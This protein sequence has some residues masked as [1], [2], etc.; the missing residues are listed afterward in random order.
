[1]T[2]DNLANRILA[3]IRPWQTSWYW[4]D[5]PVAE[6]GAAREVLTAAGL[7]IDD[8]CSRTDDPPDCEANIDGQRCGIELTTLEHEGMIRRAL[9]AIR[10]RASGKE[11]KRPEAYFVWDRETFLAKLQRIIHRKD[12]QAARAQGG[13]YARYILIIVTAEM[14]LDRD[15][16][17]RFLP[18]ACFRAEHI[19]DVFLGLDYHPDPAGG[20]GSYPTFRLELR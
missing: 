11:P 7:Q 2:E 14:F 12:K 8:L 10:E 5:K 17:Q 4:R 1:M 3:N 16:V 20:E 15:V 13:P 18:G 6:R 19:T 9:R